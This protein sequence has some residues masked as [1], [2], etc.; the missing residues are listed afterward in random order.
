MPFDRIETSFLFASL[1]SFGKNNYRIEYYVYFFFFLQ[2]RD[3]FYMLR[4]FIGNI[5]KELQKHDNC[6]LYNKDFRENS[7]LYYKS[8]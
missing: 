5:W 7:I 8:A 2:V 6:F 1:S 4:I 3:D